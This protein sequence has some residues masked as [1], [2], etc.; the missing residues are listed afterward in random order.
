[1]SWQKKYKIYLLFGD[2]KIVVAK[3]IDLGLGLRLLGTVPGHVSGS[4]GC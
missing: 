2:G 4:F 1:M 3:T